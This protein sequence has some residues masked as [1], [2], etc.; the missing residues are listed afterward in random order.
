M[1]AED[2]CWQKQYSEVFRRQRDKDGRAKRTSFVPGQSLCSDRTLIPKVG[3]MNSIIEFRYRK[4][5]CEFPLN[6]D[7]LDIFHGYC[8]INGKRH[9]VTRRWFNHDWINSVVTFDDRVLDYGEDPRVF[10]HQNQPA[11]VSVVCRP[12]YGFRNHIFE[13]DHQGF[14]RS[15]LVLPA[16]LSTGKNWSPFSFWDG[17]V[18]F[19]HSF[20]PPIILREERREQGVIVLGV[21]HG[22]N[23]V[24]EIGPGNFSCYRGGSNGI[25]INNFVFGVGHTTRFRC[26]LRGVIHRPFMWILDQTTA[27]ISVLGVGCDEFPTECHVI[28]PTSLIRLSE[29]EFEVFTTEVNRSSFHDTSGIG[30]V[31]S[32]RFSIT[33]SAIDRVAL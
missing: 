6:L 24:S 23:S 27:N 20:D 9:Q 29:T 8:E 32:Y 4:V 21:C 13:I 3:K 10:V 16:S 5:C 31:T 28:D 18:G 25:S 2:R 26:G 1:W 19:V 33:E 15:I 17:R 22:A 14:R 11:I 7:P 12:R 30:R